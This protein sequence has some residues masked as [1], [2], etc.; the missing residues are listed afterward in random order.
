MNTDTRRLPHRRALLVLPLLLIL[1]AAPVRA[2]GGVGL[3]GQI[4]DPSGLTLKLYNPGR[5]SYDFLVAWDLDDFFFLNVHGLYE[6][7]LNTT[8]D[9][10][11]FYG[12]GGFL[13][14][15]DRP[16]DE[17]DDAV[18]GISGTF[19]LGFYI[20][21]FEI[22]GQLTPRLALVPDTNGDLGGGIGVRFY[23]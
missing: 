7:R 2:Q 13:G 6:R 18:L 21:Q 9:F 10:R 11:F 20:E 3:G 19:G 23:F 1:M 15:R 17:D 5:V 22:F 12:P 16:R 8:E 4:G 14:F